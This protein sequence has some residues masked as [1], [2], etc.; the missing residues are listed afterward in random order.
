MKITYTENPLY[1]KIELDEHEKKELWYKLKI[2][3][4]TDKLFNVHYQLE[5]DEPDLNEVWRTADPAYYM[6]DEGRDP[7]DIR[8]DQMLEHYLGDLQGG[9]VGDCICVACT[10]SKCLVESMLGIDTIQGLGKHEAHKID[11]A[12]SNGCVNGVWLSDKSID[13]VLEILRTYAPVQPEGSDE[14][15]AKVG[16]FSAHVP[17]WIAEADRA[18]QWLLNYRNIHFNKGN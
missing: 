4:L 14:S 10:C 7:I 3:D 2:E 15:W 9:H 17:R 8:A 6:A 1:T 11:S 12:F 5:K 13:E 16:G 18:Y